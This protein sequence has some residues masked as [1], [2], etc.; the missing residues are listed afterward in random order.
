[1]PPFRI[2]TLTLG[3]ELTA[4]VPLHPVERLLDGLSRARRRFHDEG[5][6]VQTIRIATTPVVASMPAAARKAA[7]P[8]LRRLDEMMAARGALVSL[9]PVV[10]GDASVDGD[11][12]GWTAGLN[13][14]TTATHAS[15]RIG[16]SGVHWRAIE[17]AATIISAVARPADQGLGNFRFAAAAGVPAG[18]PFFPVAWHAGGPSALAIGIEGAPLVAGA[19]ARAGSVGGLSAEVTA[20]LFAGLA[21]VETLARQIAREEGWT[22]GGIDP[23]P[24][25]LGERSIVAAIERATGVPFG[26]PG[27]LAACSAI[28]RGVR[29]LPLATCGYSGLMLP[30]LEDAVLAARAAEGRVTLQNLLLC[31]SVCGTGL[32]VIPLP[33]DLPVGILA[34]VLADVATLAVRLGKPLAARLLPVPGLGVGDMTAFDDP[35]LVNTTVLAPV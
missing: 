30:I 13:A 8:R 12:A 10:T 32:D 24:A 2:R 9:G 28:T 34:A 22:Y 31:S 29:E 21:P 25:P 18:T 11:V 6:E 1:M 20:A 35:Y 3:T 17:V 4:G 15:V 26:G 16:D 19:A 7:L 33:G 23:S 14:S 5:F 27:T